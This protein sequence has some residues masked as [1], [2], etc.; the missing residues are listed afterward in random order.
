MGKRKSL[1]PDKILFPA[2]RACSLKCKG[3]VAAGCISGRSHSTSRWAFCK[4]VQPHHPPE[5]SPVEQDISRNGISH[6]TCVEWC[7]KFPGNGAVRTEYDYSGGAL[8]LVRFFGQTK[9]WTE[10]CYSGEHHTLYIVS[11]Y[12]VTYFAAG[13]IIQKFHIIICKRYC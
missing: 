11:T 1:S 5:E 13:I 8:S 7:L 2:R 12:Y 4:G 3:R 9:K 10:I 6:T